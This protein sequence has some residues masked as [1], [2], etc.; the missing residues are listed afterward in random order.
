MFESPP[1]YHYTVDRAR[2]KFSVFGPKI[3]VH[4]LFLIEYDFLFV[5]MENNESLKGLVSPFD[6]LSGS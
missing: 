1:G 5:F 2:F 4:Y 6:T 3:R